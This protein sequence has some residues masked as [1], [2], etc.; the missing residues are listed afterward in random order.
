LNEK[1]QGGGG[2]AGEFK[3][4]TEFDGHNIFKRARWK[5]TVRGGKR[6]RGGGT[7]PGGSN[8]HVAAKVSLA[9]A[10]LKDG[11][12]SLIFRIIL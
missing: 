11:Q 8:V 7:R 9:G 1:R 12:N 4:K 10:F 3:I 5:E 6:K 2:E